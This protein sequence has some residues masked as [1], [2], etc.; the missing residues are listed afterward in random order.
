MEVDIKLIVYLDQH[1]V[2]TLASIGAHRRCWKQYSTLA[3][4]KRARRALINKGEE[5]LK[6]WHFAR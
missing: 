5:A 6:A 2:P 1:G 4:A 3:A